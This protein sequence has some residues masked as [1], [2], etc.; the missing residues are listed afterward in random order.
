MTST[1]LFFDFLAFEWDLI[2]MALDCMELRKELPTSG[3]KFIA[4]ES[5]AHFLEF[6]NFRSR[7]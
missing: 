2:A 6:H 1:E 7:N 4:D 3:A 5:V